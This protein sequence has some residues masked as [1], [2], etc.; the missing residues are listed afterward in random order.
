MPH[1]HRAASPPGLPAKNKWWMRVEQNRLHMAPLSPLHV[2]ESK[3]LL[4]TIDETF[5]AQYK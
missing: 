1:K 4:R 5:S 2:S 3:L